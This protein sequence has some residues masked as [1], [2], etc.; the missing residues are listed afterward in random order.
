MR[1]N[2]LRYLC[3]WI[4][5]WRSRWA[6]S[7]V[8]T[9]SVPALGD[10]H[11]IYE[12]LTRNLLVLAAQKAPAGRYFSNLTPL[13]HPQELIAVVQ[14]QGLPMCVPGILGDASRVDPMSFVFAAA[15]LANHG[16]ANAKVKLRWLV[17]PGLEDFHPLLIID[18]PDGW[19]EVL[20][21]RGVN[22]FRSYSKIQD[23]FSK[24][25]NT[26]FDQLV[27]LPLPFG[28]SFNGDRP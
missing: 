16:I 23:Y 8:R 3:A 2:S 9:S 20:D 4:R 13:R 26:S 18:H 10:A 24:Q 1:A 12:F 19:L 28:L 17:G 27:E 7:G 15:Y 6:D 14:A 25:L 5:V 21:G 11:A 22:L